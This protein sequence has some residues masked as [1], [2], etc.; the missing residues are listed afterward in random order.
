MNNKKIWSEH[1]FFNPNNPILISL[2]SHISNLTKNGEYNEQWQLF[3]EIGWYNQELL[4]DCCAEI[5]KRYYKQL[6]ETF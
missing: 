5:R 3:V 2:L 6:M 1:K 4:T